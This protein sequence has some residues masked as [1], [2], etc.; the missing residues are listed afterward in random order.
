MMY[1]MPRNIENTEICMGKQL[2]IMPAEIWC[3]KSFWVHEDI[4]YGAVSQALIKAP[5]IF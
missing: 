2:V 3:I 1:L 5:A 4:G